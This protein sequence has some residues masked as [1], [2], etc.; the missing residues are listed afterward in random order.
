MNKL[1]LIILLSVIG[2]CIYAQDAIILTSGEQRSVLVK[3]VVLT[4]IEYVRFDNQQGA[5]YEV[6]KG[7]VRKIIYQNGVEEIFQEQGNIKSE[8]A[9]VL[10]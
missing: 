1:A 5:I 9:L 7:D 3:K 10:S 8:S 4:T 2:N 6:S